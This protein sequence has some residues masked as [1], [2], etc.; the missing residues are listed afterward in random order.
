LELDVIY[1]ED[2]LSGMSRIPDKSIDMIL[3]DLPYGTSACKWDVVLPFDRLWAHYRR[4][5]K[6]NA[7]IVLFSDEP[8]TSNLIRSNY[9]N[10]RYKW[11]WNKGR[12]SNFQNAR[13]MP[14][15]CHEEICVFYKK[16]PKYNPQFWFSTPYKAENRKRSKAY[17]WIG[18]KSGTGRGG[19][20]RDAYITA[21]S[22][23]GRRYPLSILSFPCDSNKVHPSQKPVALLEYLIKTYTSEGE[24][25]L[26]NCAGSGSTLVAAA[27]TNRH[28]I[29]FETEAKYFDIAWQRVFGA[30]AS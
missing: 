15:K 5:V 6:D 19:S 2:C 26:D 21:G 7:A 29:G 22:E 3:C 11:V 9:K 14:M 4:I 12:G 8:F 16:T 25:V 17:E 24:V 23:D 10:F 30:Q 28:Y 27:N 13:R 18:N 20:I 1:N